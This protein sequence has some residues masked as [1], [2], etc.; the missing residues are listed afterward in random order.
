LA[1]KRFQSDNGLVVDALVGKKTLA[2]LSQCMLTHFSQ[3]EPTTEKPNLDAPVL[4]QLPLSLSWLHCAYST[5][6]TQEI[7]GQGAN[8]TI[9]N[10]AKVQD[11]DHYT[12]DDIPWCGLFVAHC[13]SSQLDLEP[14]PSI[15][16]RARAWE[17]FGK[18]ISPQTGAIM[19]FWRVSEHSGKGHVGFY[20]GED[21]SCY[22]ILGGNQSNRVSIARIAKNRLLCARWPSTALPPSGKLV[23]T[24]VS[25]DGISS[26]EA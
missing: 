9:M 22:H 6:G 3:A 18:E 5:L 16:L 24:S 21:N 17:R 2:A 4:S 13:I 11:L 20:W 23:L 25:Q 15:V 19:V 12:D 14:L 1:I 10:W 26:N 7:V 8:P